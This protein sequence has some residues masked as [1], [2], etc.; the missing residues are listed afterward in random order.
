M[1]QMQ[2]KNKVFM[3]KMFIVPLNLNWQ[4]VKI[5]KHFSSVA[6]IKFRLYDIAK[7]INDWYLNFYIFNIHSKINCFLHY[8]TE[9][10]KFIMCFT[11]KLNYFIFI[12]NLSIY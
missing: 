10:I 2:L 1:Q 8:R 6:F 7:S 12:I 11:Q 3:F 9:I 5:N 4:I